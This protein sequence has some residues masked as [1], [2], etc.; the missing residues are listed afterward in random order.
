MARTVP[1]S[2]CDIARALRL[3]FVSASV[4]P[5]IFGS[6]LAR[7]GFHP[8]RFLLGLAAVAGTHL[9][10]NL[11]NDYADSLSGVD[12]QDT[13]YYRFFGGSKLIQE[14]R[15]S[16]WLYL[17]GSAFCAL[18]AF[19][20]VVALASLVDRAAVVALYLAVLILAWSYSARPLQLSYR[21][22]GEA[23]VFLLFGPAAVAAGWFAQSGAFPPLEALLPSLPFG[24]LTAG[25]LLANEVPDAA[26]DEAAGKR[27]LVGLVGQERG[28]I[29]Y[30][31]SAAC[32]L[33]AVVACVAGG[34]LGAWSLLSLV[35]IVP[36]G[37]A[38]WILKLHAADKAALTRSSKL[39]ILAQSVAGVALIADGLFS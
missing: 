13:T 27:T 28:F 24:F 15:A 12:W 38:A 29:L 36:A 19:A 7:A 37:A 25:I 35:A 6:V 32:A 14:R 26:E 1:G 10:A 34:C 8:L 11:L 23:V 17:V 33:A 30:T 21:R 22:L 16:P 39:A 5:F 31:A 3:P 2:L 4:L 18:C 20:A 9:S